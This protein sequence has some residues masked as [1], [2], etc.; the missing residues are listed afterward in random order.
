[1]AKSRDAFRTIS[2]VSAV[3][4]TPSH[5]LRFWESKFSQIKPVK[6]AGGRRYYRPDDVSLLLGIKKLLHEQGMTIKGAQKLLREQGVKH[7]IAIGEGPLGSDDTPQPASW[8]E[9]APETTAQAVSDL[10]QNEDAQSSKEQV[11]MFSPAASDIPDEPVIEAIEGTTAPAP[12]L[13]I[14][15]AKAVPDPDTPAEPAEKAPEVKGAVVLESFEA[16]ASQET[17][18]EEP[19]EPTPAVAPVD[20][21]L[22]VLAKQ[23]PKLP[24]NPSPRSDVLARCLAVA[25]NADADKIIANKDQIAPLLTRLT[26]LRDEMRHPW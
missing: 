21:P 13:Q 20:T 12:R 23:R 25:V 7:V 10:M 9:T 16:P 8:S 26:A 6:R 3:L 17:A 14:V 2:E 18:P 22:T 4:E 5:V 24:A 19:A 15:S 1:M 11:E